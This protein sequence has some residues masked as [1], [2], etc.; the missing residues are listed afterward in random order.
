[1]AEYENHHILI[2]I[3]FKIAFFYICMT[4]VG[5]KCAGEEQWREF[6]LNTT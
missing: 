2:E 3:P 6:L 1:M 5:Q 4:P